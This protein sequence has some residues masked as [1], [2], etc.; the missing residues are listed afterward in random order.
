MQSACDVEHR[1]GFAQ[2]KTLLGGR[3]NLENDAVDGCDGAFQDEEPLPA[4]Q[5][6]HPIHEE[7]AC[8]D[9]CANDLD[10]HNTC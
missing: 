3:T 5:A 4:P 8:R 2:R 6:A 7:D 9:G 10:Q 1:S